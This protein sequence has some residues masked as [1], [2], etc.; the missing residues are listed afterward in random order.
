[1]DLVFA[2]Q[3]AFR[4]AAASKKVARGQGGWTRADTRT[5]DT[6]TDR[7]NTLAA[8]FANSEGALLS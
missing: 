6:R 1:M 8:K 4:P 7:R 2:S 3:K 5:S